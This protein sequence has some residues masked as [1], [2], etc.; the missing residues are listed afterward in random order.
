LYED[1]ADNDIFYNDEDGAFYY[2]ASSMHF[3]PG[4]PI[5]RSYDLANWE[6]VGHSV[7][8]LS[9]FG[10]QYTLGPSSQAYRQGVW[11]STMRY[12]KSNKTWYWIGCVGFYENWIYTAPAPEGPWTESATWGG[13]CYYD[14][15][16]LIDDDDL[17]YV[18]Y[19]GTNVSLALLNEDGLSQNKTQHLFNAADVNRTTIEGNRLYKHNGNYYVLDDDTQA[20]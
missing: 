4:A 14:C 6:F 15:G 9:T 19:G 10:S 3:S 13:N 17:M 18:V 11:A 20:R 5:L 12:R 16:L 2:S 8:T 7:P 1:F